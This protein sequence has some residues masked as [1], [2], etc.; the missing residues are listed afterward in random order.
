VTDPGP[1]ANALTRLV[2]SSADR[3]AVPIAAF[4][5]ASLI[6]ASVRT[7]VSNAEANAAAQQA[8]HD[9]YRSPV[10]MTAMDLSVEAETFGCEIRLSE[11]E[12]PTVAGRLITSMADVA[13]LR[14]PHPGDGRTGVIF[15]AIGRMKQFDGAPLVFGGC[16]GPFSLAA[17]LLGV[18]EALELTLAD[19]VLVHAVLEKAAAFLG[20]HV[21]ATRAAGADGVIMAEP[22]A[23]LLSPRG[24]REF[25]AAYVRPIAEV[26]ADGHFALVLHNCAARLVHLPAVLE[27]G[28][29]VFHFGAPMDLAAA[30][31][32]VP[33]GV[34]LCGNLDPAAVFVQSSPNEITRQVHDLRRALDGFPNVVL[35]SGCD[36]PPDAPLT[37][38]DAFYEAARSP[39]LS[40]AGATAPSAP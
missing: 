13:T 16:I 32:R 6:G 11:T 12:V 10:V 23:G 26:V 37:H 19:P 20:A 7:I 29:S 25:S 3:L 4:P 40:S 17:R 21:Q 5:A 31:S 33:E 36:I 35:S 30:A 15:D 27:S 38:L 1:R 8:L 14:T 34:V 18:S 22:A 9:R 39:L 28:P 24:L 2:S